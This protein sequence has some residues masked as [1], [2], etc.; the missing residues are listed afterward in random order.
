MRANKTNFH[1]KG[2][3]LGLASKQRSKAT[4]KSPIY[5]HFRKERILQNLSK[6]SS[7]SSVNFPF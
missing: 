4:Q 2:F 3:A 7:V 5:L 6:T 1:M